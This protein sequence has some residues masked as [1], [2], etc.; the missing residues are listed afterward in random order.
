MKGRLPTYLIAK[1][2]PY[3]YIYFVS[4][5]PTNFYLKILKQ[6]SLHKL[7][8]LGFFCSVPLANGEDTVTIF[9]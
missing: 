6:K 9:A 7:K 3:N 8:V 1:L 2:N 5:R 4:A